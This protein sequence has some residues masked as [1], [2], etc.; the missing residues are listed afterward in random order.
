MNL[1]AIEVAFIGTFYFGLV[2]GVPM[3][4]H[5]DALVFSFD[6]FHCSDRNYQCL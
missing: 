5:S 4:Q 2:D 1:C 3:G 6:R